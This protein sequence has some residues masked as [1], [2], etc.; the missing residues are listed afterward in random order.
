MNF[1]KRPGHL[2]DLNLGDRSSTLIQE[3]IDAGVNVI[4]GV[5]IAARC[6]CLW[7]KSAFQTD[8]ALEEYR[9]LLAKSLL[10]EE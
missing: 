3:A 5:E 1:L 9:T 4:S 10:S 2:F 6:D 7:A 8:L